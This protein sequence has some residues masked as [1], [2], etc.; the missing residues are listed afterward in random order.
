MKDRP[1]LF[2]APMVRAI[3]DGT[4]TQ[5]RRAV[6]PQ[7]TSDVRAAG[8][9]LS[10]TS[11]CAEGTWWWLDSIDIMEANVVGEAFRCPYGQPGDRLWVRETWGPCDGGFCYRADE[12]DGSPAKP[13]DGRWHPSIHMFRAAS[14]ITLEVTG[15][16]VER[17]QDISEA[18]A[19]AE[20]IERADTGIPIC[21]AKTWYRVLW[22]QINGAGS[23]DAKPWVWVVEF[24]RVTP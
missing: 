3:L 15:V 11:P 10:S 18:D 19:I 7:P 5:T 2:S 22:E 17:L 21:D 14:R 13:D 16:R 20:G 24:K 23:W 1:I 6:K 9:I 12:R 8:A 4:K